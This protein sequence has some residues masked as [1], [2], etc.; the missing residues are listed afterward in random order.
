M[1]VTQVD[2][3]RVK[4]GKFTDK[5]TIICKF[6][7]ESTDVKPALTEQHNTSSFLEMDTGNY[8][9]WSAGRMDWIM[10]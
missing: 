1:A 7:G 6:E 2:E 10:L 9:K 5:E 8:Y 4:F 3:K